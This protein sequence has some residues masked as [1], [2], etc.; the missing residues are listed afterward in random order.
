MDPQLVETLGIMPLKNCNFPYFGC[1][2]E[3]WQKLKMLIILKTDR[4]SIFGQIM[5]P[6]GTRDT[7][8]SVSEVFPNFRQHLEVWWK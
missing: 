6:L 1:Y 4:A 2:L 7:E 3:F 8:Y 5:D